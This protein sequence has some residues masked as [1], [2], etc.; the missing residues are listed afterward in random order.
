MSVNN[1][2]IYFQNFSNTLTNDTV[3][4]TTAD[5]IPTNSIYL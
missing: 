4:Y 5:V 2:A 1:T 3:Q